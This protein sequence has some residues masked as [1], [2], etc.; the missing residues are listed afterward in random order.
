[1]NSLEIIYQNFPHCEEWRDRSFLGVLHEDCRIETS[2][3]WLLEWALVSE[4]KDGLNRDPRLCWPV[5]RIFS[6]LMSL[7]KSNLDP[8]DG[9]FILDMGG[10][11]EQDFTERLQMVFE[12]FFQGVTSDLNGCFERPNPLLHGLNPGGARKGKN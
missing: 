9:Y 6:R 12:G 7:L 3:Y 8:R 5:F 10:F 4:T 11:D 1:M 2:E